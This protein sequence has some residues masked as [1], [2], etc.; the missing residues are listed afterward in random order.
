MEDPDWRKELRSYC[1]EEGFD[2]IV[3]SAPGTEPVEN[4][5]PFLKKD[6]MLICFQEPNMEAMQNFQSDMWQVTEQGLM[7]AADL[8]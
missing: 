7:R 2:D 6:G 1:K 8:R 3:V 5:V 4:A